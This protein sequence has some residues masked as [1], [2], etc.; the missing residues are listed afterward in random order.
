[1][2][3]KRRSTFLRLIKGPF[4]NCKVELKLQRTKFCVLTSGG[5]DRNDASFTSI[6][7]STKDT[8]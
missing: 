3:L 5:V 1:M 2:S 6:A 8:I 7:C 4:I